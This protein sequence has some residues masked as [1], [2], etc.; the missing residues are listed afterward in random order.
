MLS[1]PEAR[2]LAALLPRFLG[3]LPSA[4]RIAVARHTHT[5]LGALNAF[6]EGRALDR[7][8]VATALV[9]LEMEIR[10]LHRAIGGSPACTAER[11][12]LWA[13]IESITSDM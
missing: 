12:R 8:T 11:E 2:R 7:Q 9:F 5:A 6:A 3:L 1:Q 10:G 4:N 13:E